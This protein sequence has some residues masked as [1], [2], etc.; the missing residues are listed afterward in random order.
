MLQAIFLQFADTLS[1]LG[2]FKY[3]T[4]RAGGA[5][6]TSFLITFMI[7]PKLILTLKRW[8][9]NGQPLRDLGS[10]SHKD[11]KKGTPTMGGLII[12]IT[13][14][15]STLLWA[16]LA[17]PFVWVMLVSTLLFAAIGMYDDY[18]KLIKNNSGGISAKL[19]LGLQIIVAGAACTVIS[20]LTD[21]GIDSVLTF[22]FFKNLMIDLGCFYVIFAIIVII[23]SSNA[24]NLTDGLDGLATAP[25]MV[26][27]AVFLIIAYLVGNKFFADYLN[28]S[29][30]AGTGEIA[31]FLGALI[32]SCMGFLWFNAPPAKIFMGDTGSLALGGVLGVTAVAT[33]HEIILAV[34][35]GLFVIEAMSVILQ[36]ASIRLRGKKIFKIAPIHHHFE[37][38]GWAETTVVVRFWIIAIVFGLLALAT[39]KLR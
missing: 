13:L 34:A 30:I 7:A 6:L 1:F 8:Q 21:D 14:C 35:G 38:S 39:L 15:L 18:E 28:I 23:G 9:K 27:S 17:N 26:C 3:I 12:I 20:V 19:K 4:F 29:Y 37:K 5:V 25:V 32:G 36:V 16:N 11:K 33:K 24:V 31:V 10:I 2:V 22:P